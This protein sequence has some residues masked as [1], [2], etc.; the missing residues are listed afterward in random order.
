M[1]LL[2]LINHL[3]EVVE[4]H[5]NLEVCISRTSSNVSTYEGELTDSDISLGLD[6]NII[7]FS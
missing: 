2:Q 1:T 3:K 7:I 5:G 4:E 6:A